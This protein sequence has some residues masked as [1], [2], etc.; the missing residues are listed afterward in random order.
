MKRKTGREKN[1]DTKDKAPE[2]KEQN[3]REGLYKY[4]KP[5]KLNVKYVEDEENELRKEIM[6]VK[7]VGV[8]NINIC[9][10]VVRKLV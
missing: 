8:W 10:R 4:F 7:R 9:D 3:R 1:A 2:T 5:I 6:K